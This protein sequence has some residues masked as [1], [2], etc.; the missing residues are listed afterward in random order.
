MNLNFSLLDEPIPLRGGTILVLEDVCVFSKIVQY[1]YQYEE[2][3]ELKFFDHKM[4][5]I[6]ESEIMLVTDILGFDVNSSTILKLIHADLESQFNEKPEV[7]SM[8]DKLVA[9]ITELIVFEFLENELDLEY[10]EI[11]ILELIKCLGVKVETQSDTI[12][13]KC[14]EILQIFKYLTK[15]KLLIFV[16]SGAYLTKDEVASLQEYISLT[17]LTVLFL[18]PRELY[19]FPQ[20]ILDEDYFLITK[21]MV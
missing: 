16:N 21:N 19:D 9:T 17:N 3:S 18:E 20:Y 6:K 7:K 2:D 13:E 1:C 11:T 5:T 12:F 8:I 15:K 10:D 14:L 4:K